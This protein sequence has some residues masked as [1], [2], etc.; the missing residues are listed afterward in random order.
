M[1]GMSNI[2][3]DMTTGVPGSFDKSR[4]QTIKK[5]YSTS[6]TKLPL[7][8]GEMLFFADTD[9]KPEC[10]PATYTTSDGCAC[11]T[12]SQTNYI[13]RRGGNGGGL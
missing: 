1:E 7:P 8:P 11:L 9:F 6:G 2:E 3:D 5:K 10:C 4:V 12:D 13:S